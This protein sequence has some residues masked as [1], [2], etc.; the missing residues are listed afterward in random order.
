VALRILLL[1]NSL[2]MGGAE[3]HTLQLAGA[4]VERGADVTVDALRGGG[5]FEISDQRIKLRSTGGNG[6]TDLG[7]LRRLARFI[8]AYKP[9]IVVGVSDRPLYYARLARAFCR[10]RF[11]LV[12]IRHGTGFA[13]PRDRLLAPLNRH[14]VN[15]CDLVIYVS[16]LQRDWWASQGY[17]GK[18]SS[19]ILN[20]VDVSHFTVPTEEERVARRAALGIG[21]NDLVLGLCA[22]LRPEKNVGQLIEATARLNAKGVPARAVIVGD[23]P[24][25]ASLRSAAAALGIAARVL[26]AGTQKDVRPW[27]AA[28]DV[29]ILCST[30]IETMSLAALEIMATG[31]PMILSETGG[32]AEIVKPGVNGFLYPVGGL[33]ELVACAEKFRDRALCRQMGA[34]ARSIVESDF[35]LGRM[36][37]QYWDALSALQAARAE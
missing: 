7:A 23:G 33:T 32:A 22:A 24:Q 12:T 25:A 36:F 14:M 29:G 15:Q 19:V 35:S 30:R 18:R 8:D 17:R 5:H 13:R 27:L 4:L 20:A 2:G 34:N 28:F 3:K 11:A 9:D 16:R 21:A 1:V 31:R 26:F 10:T 37:D 6:L